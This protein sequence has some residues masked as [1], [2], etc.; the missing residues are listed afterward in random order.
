MIIGE[1]GEDVIDEKGG[2]KLRD[3]CNSPRA[4]SLALHALRIS[5]GFIGTRILECNNIYDDIEKEETGV[6]EM[7]TLS[8]LALY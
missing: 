7:S 5:D 3:S 8:V 6:S 4:R 2:K 1:R